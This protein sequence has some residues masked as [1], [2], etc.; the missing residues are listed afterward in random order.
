MIFHVQSWSVCIS[1]NNKNAPFGTRGSSVYA[2]DED[3]MTA[4]VLADEV[5]EHLEGLVRQAVAEC[6]RCIEE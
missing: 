1:E 6:V 5:P 3:H 2:Y 4:N